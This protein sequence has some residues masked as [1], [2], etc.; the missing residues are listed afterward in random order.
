M[1]PR[2][3]ALAA[4]LTLAA[5]LAGCG[6]GA[7]AGGGEARVLVTRDFGARTLGA[8]IESEIP[9]SETAM[10][11]LQRNFRVTTRYGGG[12]VQSIDGLAGGRAHGRPLDWL[13]YV[14]GIEASK[15]ALDIAVHP[16]DRIWWDF[17]DWGAATTVPA[18][19][20]QFP[21][22]FLHGA[23]GKRFPVVLECAAD[24]TDA[25]AQVSQ[26]L[27]NAGV[28]A[29]RQTLGTGV[30]QDTVRVFVGRWRELRGDAALAQI[31]RGPG[32]SGVYARFERGGAALALLD[33]TGAVARTLGAGAGLVA[34]TRY[35]EQA[36]TWAITGTD[37]AGVAAAARAL[38]ER[39]LARR[40]ALALAP[41]GGV[42]VPV[43]G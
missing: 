3:A 24:A 37:A 17:H 29:G 18:V 21:E 38:D 41:A 16:G 20:G 43:G 23:G 31:D 7:G 10:R 42:P 11:M 19:V 26:R 39:T 33:P 32:A 40:F 25:C 4:V 2:L 27:A 35:Q 28:I 1:S 8:R 13:F 5:G 6:I 12:F 36:P 14:N 30:G 15:G 22:P 34:A 9:G